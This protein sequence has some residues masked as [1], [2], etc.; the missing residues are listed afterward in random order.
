MNLLRKVLLTGSSGHLG[1]KTLELLKD[2]YE[3]H[4]LVR[5]KPSTTHANVAYH[6]IDLSRDWSTSELPQEMDVVIHLAQPRDYRSFPEHS[7]D[8]FRIN[9]SATALLLDYAR[10]AGVTHFI[11]ASTGGLYRPGI[12]VIDDKT[13]ISPPQG[14]LSYYFRTKQ[15]AELLADSYKLLFDVSVLRPFFIYGPGQSQEKLISRLIESVRKRRTISLSGQYGIRINPVHVD[16]V[17]ELICDLP[18]ISGSRTLNVAG[19]DVVSIRGIAEA[20]GLLCD[21]PPVFEC[22]EGP[23]EMIVADSSGFVSLL[24]RPPTRFSDGLRTLFL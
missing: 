4:A 17:A 21:T 11:L 13:P 15:S 18:D 10:R 22:V 12:T 14:D 1:S 16:D 7:L 5:N 9:T 24:R 20:V 3:V 8:T 23:E 19:P 6:E 2:Q